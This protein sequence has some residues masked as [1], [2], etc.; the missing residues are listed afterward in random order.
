ME[1]AGNEGSPSR[2]RT[3]SGAAGQPASSALSGVAE[4]LEDGAV[5]AALAAMADA[6]LIVDSSGVVRY[7]NPAA[8]ELL[9]RGELTGQPLG[10][11]LVGGKL[12]EVDL[13]RPGLPPAVA[14]MRVAVMKWRGAPA[15]CAALR[16]VTERK[17]A[18]AQRL[19]LAAAQAARHQ[20]EAAVL[21]RDE[22]LSVAAHELK[23]PL[24]SL[25][26]GLQLT[27]RQLS[28][29]RSIDLSGIKQRLE[30]LDLEA[31]K[32][33]RLVAE[34]LDVSRVDRGALV[35]ERQP[36]DLAAL[37]GNVV[38]NLSRLTSS[39]TITLDA[40]SRLEANVD[41]LRIEQVAANLVE[42]AIKYSPQGG[43]IAV[44]LRANPESPPA[45]HLT[46]RDW[47]I[48]IPPERRDGLFSRFYQAHPGGTTAGLGL[49]LYISR[50]IVELHGGTIRADFPSDGGTSFSVTLPLR[51]PVV[52]AQ[53]PTHPR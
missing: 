3:P 41:P 23:T 45:A 48:G 43:R 25:R 2:T 16:D 8:A 46:V 10:F 22:F 40:P 18:E 37:T 49:G 52:P 14:E 6:V 13:V 29:G 51:L 19:Q 44:T 26:L 35:L 50:Q 36:T 5:T 31:G 21:A 11:P 9:G 1:A 47:G 32:L 34:L 53:P 12:T 42:N 24:T 15:Y 4:T 7:A 39:H 20:A 17:E 38:S 28:P 27:A 33:S 30:S